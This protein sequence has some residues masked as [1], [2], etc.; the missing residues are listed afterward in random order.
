MHVHGCPGTGSARDAME[1]AEIAAWQIGNVYVYLYLY[2]YRYVYVYLYLYLYRYVYVYVYVYFYV[3]VYVYAYFYVYVYVYFYVYVHVYF[4]AYVYVSVC[5]Y[6]YTSVFIYTYDL[7]F[8][9]VCFQWN[10]HRLPFVPPGRLQ[11]STLVAWRTGNFTVFWRNP[12]ETD[13]NWYRT[14]RLC[15]IGLAAISYFHLFT[16]TILLS[17][18]FQGT[19]DV[20]NLS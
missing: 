16:R 12:A 4:Y 9:P 13:G 19:V 5:I 11:N 7:T 2:L 15:K 10:S 20:L 17:Y 1:F 18:S 8:F 6:L 3:Y 14:S